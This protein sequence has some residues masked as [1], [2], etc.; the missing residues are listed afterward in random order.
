MDA[1]SYSGLTTRRCSVCSEMQDA[2]GQLARW[3]FLLREFDFEVVHRKGTQHRN[4]DALSRYP[5]PLQTDEVR[6]RWVCVPVSEDQPQDL[7]LQ[8]DGEAADPAAGKT[9]GSHRR[10]LRT[11]YIG[12]V[13]ALYDYG[14]AVVGTHAAPATRDRLEAEQNKC[15][16]IITGCIRLTRT[17]ALLAEADLP[18]LSLRAK[19]LAAQE[20]QRI[21]R[22]PALD[23]A[24]TLLEKEMPPRLKYR[25]HQAWRRACE[26]AAEEQRRV[27]R[28][29]LPV[30]N[31]RAGSAGGEVLR[32]PVVS[33]GLVSRP[34]T[35]TSPSG[36]SGPRARRR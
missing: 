35:T 29:R 2:E 27:H 14:A 13:R 21:A 19:Q 9:W 17:D 15:A 6:Y 26:Q 11:A 1:V 36:V 7:Q 22:L 4:A 23:P 28:S 32:H 33:T 8:V 3:Q 18:P 10:T 25:A 20:C 30:A 24:R 16:R 31:L 5:H 12:Y 34:T